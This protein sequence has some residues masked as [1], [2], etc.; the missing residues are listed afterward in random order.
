MHR[1]VDGAAAALAGSG[2]IPLTTG[3]QDLEVTLRR[4][5]VP[6][7]TTRIFDRRERRVWLEVNREARQHR[8][9]WQGTQAR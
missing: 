1:K 8:F 7:T 5:R 6:A 3:C 2:V 9:A 4:V